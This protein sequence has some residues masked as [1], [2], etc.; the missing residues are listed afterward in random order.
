MKLMNSELT[1]VGSVSLMLKNGNNILRKMYYNNGTNELFEAY[2]RALSGQPI[3][4]FIPS[5]IE[6][7]KDNK[8]IVKH[9]IPVT[10][11]YVAPDTP[12]KAPCT[13]VSALINRHMFDDITGESHYLRLLS[14]GE[15]ELAK[16]RLV[17]FN[18]ILKGLSPGVQIMISWDLYIQNKPGG[19]G[20]N[21]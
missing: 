15:N 2:A 17:G 9:L 10:T 18:E 7:V 20:G 16:V 14:F 1:Y 5:Y 4:S 6:I 13:R 21:E 8:S 19:N 12:D 11:T 3:Q